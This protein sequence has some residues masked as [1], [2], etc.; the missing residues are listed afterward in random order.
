MKCY[1]VLCVVVWCCVVLRVPIGTQLRFFSGCGLLA[2]A[3]GFDK[4]I[5]QKNLRWWVGPR[6]IHLY[7]AP[8][9]REEKLECSSRTPREETC[10]VIGEKSLIPMLEEWACVSVTLYSI[11]YLPEKI[12]S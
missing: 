8:G 1:A 6:E 3:H 5:V 4:F 9:V 12:V 10:S 2:C 11:P 7:I